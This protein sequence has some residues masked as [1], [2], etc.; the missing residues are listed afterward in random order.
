MCG[1]S[2]GKRCDSILRGE[3]VHENGL[4]LWLDESGVLLVECTLLLAFVV[5]VIVIALAAFGKVSEAKVH[6]PARRIELR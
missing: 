5:V 6:P 1:G 3:I 2:C 4:A